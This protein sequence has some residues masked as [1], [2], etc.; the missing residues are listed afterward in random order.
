M[1]MKMLAIDCQPQHLLYADRI[2]PISRE[3]HEKAAKRAFPATKCT[4]P[5]IPSRSIMMMN[6]AA[7]PIVPIFECSPSADSGISSSTTT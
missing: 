5:K 1:Y 4:Q 2:A 7:T 6:P 3:G